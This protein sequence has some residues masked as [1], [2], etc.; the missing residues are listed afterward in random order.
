MVPVP[1]SSL[2][3]LLPLALGM[4]LL[5]GCSGSPADPPTPFPLSSA[6]LNLIFVS[7]Q[8]LSFNAL[9]D[10]NPDTANLTN[11]GLQRSLRL[12]TYLQDAVLGAENVTAIYA[13][14]PT[15]HPQT[16]Q[17]YPDMNGLLTVEQ[18][19]M[20]NQIRLS[21]PSDPS[22]PP[23]PA[24]SFPI[25][26]SYSSAAVPESVAQPLMNC[27]AETGGAYS[28]QGLDFR[29]LNLANEALVDGI[30]KQGTAGFYV[31]SAPWQTVS[32]LMQNINRL[33]GFGLNTPAS[34]AGPD[35]V[36][37]ISIAPS[38]RASLLTLNSNIDPPSDYPA[39]P[40]GGIVSAA[41]LPVTTNTTFQ[42]QVTGG[43]GTAVTP[44]GIN[45]SET[46]YLVRHA[47]AHPTSWWRTAITWGPVSGVRWTCQTRWRARSSLIWSIRSIRRRSRRALPARWALPIPMFG[48]TRPCCRMP[49]PTT[50]RISSRAAS[51]WPLENPPQLATDAAKFF[52]Y[53]GKFSNQTP[54]WAGSMITSANRECAA[55][56]LPWRAERARLAWQ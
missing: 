46:V 48:R 6:N 12:G 5:A 25:N 24:S 4:T 15:T 13:M 49:S 18:F 27:P 32:T 50:C 16:A 45:T 21:D 44:A 19:A 23:V 1:R 31:F 53:G 39:L 20:L 3:L 51:K 11:R 43:T 14:I 40:A 7:S 10:V 52:F 35:Y 30:I 17:N 38:G 41:C 56:C 9:G 42:F 55:F 29:D 2:L 54:L 33:E 47:E 34:Y 36:H 8:D 37:A 22:N 28:C 26:I